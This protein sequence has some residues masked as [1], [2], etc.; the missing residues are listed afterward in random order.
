MY[1]HQNGRTEERA[2]EPGANDAMLFRTRTHGFL[3]IVR[4]DTPLG[5][6]WMYLLGSIRMGDGRSLLHCQFHCPRHSEQNHLSIATSLEPDA[7]LAREFSTLQ[8]ALKLDQDEQGDSASHY[9][10]EDTVRFT[11]AESHTAK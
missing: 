1:E 11:E 10:H 6:V 3:Q 4:W 7:L 8:S 9:N 2:N 5:A